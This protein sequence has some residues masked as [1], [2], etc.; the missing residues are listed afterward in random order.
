MLCS[1]GLQSKSMQLLKGRNIYFSLKKAYILWKNRKA[2]MI[3][4]KLFSSICYMVFV[5]NVCGNVYRL[6]VATRLSYVESL[7][8]TEHSRWSHAENTII[9]TQT[10]VC[11]R[12]ILFVFAVTTWMVF[13][14][15]WLHDG[16]LKSRCRTLYTK[17][18]LSF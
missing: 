4:Q 3:K 10:F 6:Q 18:N 8:Q 16:R 2:M 1:F 14:F 7:K 9:R 5:L 12:F 11:W 15:N 13:A 17:S